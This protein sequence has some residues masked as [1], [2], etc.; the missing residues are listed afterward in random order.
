LAA[1]KIASA[2]LSGSFFLSPSSSVAYCAHI[3]GK[4]CIHPIAPAEDTA[5]LRPKS[6][7]MRLI[8]ASR[9]HGTP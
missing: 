8:A 3:E 9:F 2:G 1:A 7:S 5:M 6:V 4:N